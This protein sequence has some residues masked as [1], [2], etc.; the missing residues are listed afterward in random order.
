LSDREFEI[1]RLLVAGK[2][3]NEIADLLSISNKTVSTHKI[4]LMGKM[5]LTNAAELVHY[6]IEKNLFLY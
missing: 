5:D 6:A 3:V 2:R 1:F 4:H